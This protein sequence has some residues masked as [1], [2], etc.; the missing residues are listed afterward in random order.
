MRG[1]QSERETLSIH[2]PWQGENHFL[3][4]V[5]N[6]EEFKR[7]YLARPEEFNRN[8]FAAERIHQQVD[9]LAKAIR[10]AVEEESSGKLA[11]ERG[12]EADV[13]VAAR[14]DEV[15]RLL[16]DDGLQRRPEGAVVRRRQQVVP[17]GRRL[18]KRESIGV[19][20]DDDQPVVKGGAVA[21]PPRQGSSRR[22]RRR[23]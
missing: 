5:F 15:D 12:E 6:L 7:T 11:A 14:D 13:V 4:R 1:S 20:A 19:G 2:K 10:P 22:L 9:E 21:A 23:A 8:L 17:V 18:A 16:G 3:Q